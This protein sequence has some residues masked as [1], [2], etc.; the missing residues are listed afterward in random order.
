MSQGIVRTDRAS[1]TVPREHPATPSRNYRRSYWK[2]VVPAAVVVA[3]VVVFPWLF[4]LYTSMLEFQLGTAPTFIGLHNFIT[5]FSDPEFG[6]AL[7]RTLYF[8]VLAVVA[9]LVLGILAA[10]CF[11]RRFALRGLARSIFILPMM[12][13]PVAIAMV[14][15]MMF[16]PQFGVLN[17][18]LSR[19]GL[20]P[21][22]WIYNVNTVIPTLAVVETWQWTPLVML[23][24]L[25]G[26]ASLPAEPYEAA[27]LDGANA[28]HEFRHITLPLISPFVVVAAV[29]R[30]IEA[31]KAFDLIYVMTQGG[32]GN[33]SETLNIFL[34]Q[35]AFVNYHI[36]YASAVA[37]VF[38]VLIVTICFTWFQLRR[39]AQWQ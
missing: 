37:L 16:N 36:G 14:W 10:L 23:I 12:A 30:C 20:P 11:Q 34:Y 7:L 31:L 18:L 32:P 2:F 9:P 33:A 21:S 22:Q 26:L 19:I 13:T 27:A 8:G 25:G 5:L 35:T 28:W 39:V 17:Y 15:T 24:V 29:L 3:A 4:T 6:W 1:V 38:F